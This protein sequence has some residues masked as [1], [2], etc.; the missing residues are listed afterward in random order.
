MEGG[1]KPRLWGKQPGGQPQ[2]SHM[3]R[4]GRQRVKSMRCWRKYVHALASPWKRNGKFDLSE[5]RKEG[6]P[7]VLHGNSKGLAQKAVLGRKSTVSH[8]RAKH[9]SYLLSVASGAPTVEGQYLSRWLT[10]P[11]ELT[12]FRGTM[13]C[14]H[15]KDSILTVTLT[16]PNQEAKGVFR[17]HP[18]LIAE[19]PCFL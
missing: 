15:P 7:A 4:R 13:A 14:L 2:S 6:K 11:T 17:E 3:V 9:S 1:N 16:S 5:R 18:K 8:Q 19:I 10:S 12:H